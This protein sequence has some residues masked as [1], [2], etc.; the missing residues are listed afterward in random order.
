MHPCFHRKAK[1]LWAQQNSSWSSH[2]KSFLFGGFVRYLDSRAY[3]SPAHPSKLLFPLFL[4]WHEELS[5]KSS[6]SLI[7]H[8]CLCSVGRETTSLI[9]E[10]KMHASS[11]KHSKV[12]AV[13]V[14]P[15]K[16]PTGRESQS[17]C[18]KEDHRLCFTDPTPSSHLRTIPTA[19]VLLQTD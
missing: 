6:F 17:K 12:E 9:W 7:S 5:P 15:Q 18:L 8:E 3:F 11:R 16:C 19:Q 2:K 4:V 10:S 13:W 14:H 1:R